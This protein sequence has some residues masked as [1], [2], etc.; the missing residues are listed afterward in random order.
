MRQMQH[1]DAGCDEQSGPH[2][3]GASCVHLGNLFWIPQLYAKAWSLYSSQ[4]RPK[5]RT[6]CIWMPPI[7][8]IW[9]QMGPMLNTD[10]VWNIKSSIITFIRQRRYINKDLS[11]SVSIIKYS[12][13][14]DILPSC[15]LVIS[16]LPQGHLWIWT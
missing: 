13:M 2:T 1:G 10:F 16:A 15:D 12:R 14:H 3:D 4:Q 11:V 5:R 9:S 8:F 7:S 6:N